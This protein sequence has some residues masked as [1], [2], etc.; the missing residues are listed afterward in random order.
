VLIA[1]VAA[2]VVGG[3]IL[4]IVNL[5]FLRKKSDSFNVFSLIDFQN[6]SNNKTAIFLYFFEDK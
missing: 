1:V 3:K 5:V 6:P 4:E 2:T